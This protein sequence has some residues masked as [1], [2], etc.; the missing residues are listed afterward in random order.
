MI[1]TIVARPCAAASNAARG[2]LSRLFDE[3]SAL[4]HLVNQRVGSAQLLHG[5]EARPAPQNVSLEDRLFVGG[6][7]SRERLPQPVQVG[8]RPRADFVGVRGMS[9][10]LQSI[11]VAGAI[12][13]RIRRGG[14]FVHRG[15]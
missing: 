6:Q 15:G 8:A 12:T 7:C 5:G 9:G 3:R 10:S 2:V 4:A 1:R 14:H 13:R 11:V